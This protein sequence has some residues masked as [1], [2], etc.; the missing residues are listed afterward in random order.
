MDW[1]QIAIF[2][3]DEVTPTVNTKNTIQSRGFGI[4]NSRAMAIP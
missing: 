1:L 2:K 3:L 4:T